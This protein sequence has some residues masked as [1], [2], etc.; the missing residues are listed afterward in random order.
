MK[1]LFYGLGSIGCRHLINITNV[2]KELGIALEIHAL[3][4]TDKPL[5]EGIH[6]R[7]DKVMFD[8][9]QLDSDY[10]IA[11]ITN[12]T[13]Y[14]FKAITDML[15][16]SKHMFIEKPLFDSTDYQVEELAWR[17]GSVYY[18]A[19]PL[20]YT[21]VVKALKG[22]VEEESIYSVRAICSSYL[23]DWRPNIDYRTVYSAKRSEGGGVRTDLIHEWDY[24]THLFGFP[25]QLHCLSGTFSELEIDSEDVAIYIAAYKD[26]LV[27]V[28]LDY[29]GRVPQRKIE[30]F[31][32]EGTITADFISKCIHYSDN[33]STI[34]LTRNVQDMYVEEM[35]HFLRLVVDSEQQQ[36]SGHLAHVLH[37]YEV[38]KLSTGRQP[39]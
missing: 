32:R 12:P 21:G 2:S 11:F 39:G 22:I 38:L 5:N 28:H 24:I 30:L 31:T 4:S 8:V 13:G 9:T 16:R 29:F 7:I 15:G 1:I 3:R 23:P 34:D 33:R 35:R 25:E 14:H 36:V 6:A 10:D 19:A 18:V 20:R 17:A 37:A 27:E 26:K